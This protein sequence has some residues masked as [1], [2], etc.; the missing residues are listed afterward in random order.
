MSFA[1]RLKPAI[2]H[3]LAVI[4]RFCCMPGWS[5]CAFGQALLQPDAR[6]AL[7]QF[8][9]LSSRPTLIRWMPDILA[10][11]TRNDVVTR[12]ALVDA[13]CGQASANHALEIAAVDAMNV[14]VECLNTPAFFVFSDWTVLTPRDAKQRG[15]LGPDPANGRGSGTAYYLIEKRYA[16]PFAD[17]F[18][19]ESE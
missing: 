19:A 18:P 13:K 5:A 7:S 17:V 11:S 10:W 8:L 15:W 14:Y 6:N 4:S 12:I 9:D 2:D 1:V 3:E 16:R